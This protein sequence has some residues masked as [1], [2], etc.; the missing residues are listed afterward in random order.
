MKY[1]G[2]I[3]AVRYNR[4]FSIIDNLGAMVDAVLSHPSKDLDYKMFETI[5]NIPDGK[6]LSGRQGHSLTITIDNIIFSYNTQ[7]DFKAEITKYASVYTKIILESI[8]KQF[9]IQKINRYGVII[10]TELT[11]GNP[12][13]NDVYNVLA[14]N[15]SDLDSVSF[16]YNKTMNKPVLASDNEITKDYENEI[17]TFDRPSAESPINFLVDYQKYF[18]PTHKHIEDAKPKF[19]NYVMSCVDKFHNSYSNNGK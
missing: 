13:F 4:C 16:R 6:M 18:S 17:I 19:E 8:F 2:F 7:S 14:K 11:K 3:I 10:R 15:Q 1:T 9:N 5:H 12:L